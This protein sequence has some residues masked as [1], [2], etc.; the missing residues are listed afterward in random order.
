MTRY[1]EDGGVAPVPN[2]RARLSAVLG[3]AVGP[4]EMQAEIL[5]ELL[6]TLE[7]TES[8]ETNGDRADP[9]VHHLR[10]P[11]DGAGQR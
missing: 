3:R 2:L 8:K 7:R 9:D 11:G 1:R 6:E 5:V 10:R 4:K